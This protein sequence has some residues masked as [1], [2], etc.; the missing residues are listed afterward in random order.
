MGFGRLKPYSG[1]GAQWKDWCFKI[2][3]WLSQVNHLFETLTTKRDKSASEPEE[4]EEEGKVKGRTRRDHNRG[5]V[6]Q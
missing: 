5:R 1:E 4:P 6:V 2:T 3:T